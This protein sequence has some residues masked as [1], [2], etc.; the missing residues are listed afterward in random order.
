MGKNV[1]IFGA[2]GDI[3]SEIAVHLG[4]LGY[5]LVLHYHQ[6]RDKINEIYERLENPTSILG[7][8]QADLTKF[9]EI[10]RCL[11]EIWYPVDAI[12]F[13]S[14]HSYTG[15]F[16]E[17]PVKEMD[18]LLSVHVKAPWMICKHLLPQ[19]IQRKSGHII[20]IT[21]IWGDYGA[22][23][24]VVYSSVKGAQSSFVKALAKEVGPSGISVN[25]ISP[26]FIETKMNKQFTKEERLNIYSEIP[27]N[28][29]GFPSEIAFTVQF[30]LDKRSQYIQGE[31]IRINGAWI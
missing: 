3:G 23:N 25:G 1:L 6:N 27:L 26:G 19:M 13:A 10:T 28:R 12:I 2:S 29:G 9:T 5:S 24:E 31:I 20:F 15:I 30:L 8:F 18:D 14:G 16:Q 11:D 4:N 21:S 22:S 7:Y 17:M